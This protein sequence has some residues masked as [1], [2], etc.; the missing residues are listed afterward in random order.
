MLTADHGPAVS[1][2]MNTVVATRAGK[3]LISSLASG[4]L[5]IGPRFSGGLDDAAAMF[6]T[7]RDNALTPREFVDQRRKN[8]LGALSRSLVRWDGVLIGLDSLRYRT[9]DQVGE[10]H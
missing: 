8:K 4:L 6:S 1:G 9:Q 5:M 2:T 10:Q 3:V 7:A